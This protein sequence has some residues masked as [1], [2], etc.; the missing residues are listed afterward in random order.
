MSET[1]EY[2]SILILYFKEH[3]SREE[4]FRVCQEI[5]KI[6]ERTGYEVVSFQG[7][8]ENK[9]EIISVDK[10]TIVEDIQKYI[11]LKTEKNE[12]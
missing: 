11:D 5:E 7:S 4:W 6:K 8:D 12:E 2:K 9:A 1:K 10:A 3:F